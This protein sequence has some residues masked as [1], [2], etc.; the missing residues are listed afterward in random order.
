MAN[1]HKSSNQDDG[2]KRLERASVGANGFKRD[3]IGLHVVFAV[4]WLRM[5][6]F[7]DCGRRIEPVDS[8]DVVVVVVVVA[9]HHSGRVDWVPRGWPRFPDRFM[10]AQALHVVQDRLAVVVLGSV[11][12]TAA[13]FRCLLL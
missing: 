2:Y 11:T 10:E 12:P 1:L 9:G 8:I 5:P 3:S 7:L 13:Q 4:V 6:R